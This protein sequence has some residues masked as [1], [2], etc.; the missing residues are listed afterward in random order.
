MIKYTSIRVMLAL[1]AHNS[2]EIEQIDVKKALLHGELND[3]IY[4]RQ[5]E[6]YEEGR[7]RELDCKLKKSLYGLKQSPWQWNKGFNSIVINLGFMKSYSD[8]CLYYKG[9]N[10]EEMV[11]ILIYVDD[12]LLVSS[13][14]EKIEK[15]KA[16]ISFE[17]EIKDLSHAQ[18]ILGICFIREREKNKLKIS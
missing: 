14:K 4:M 1:E 10:V 8:A 5:P 3:T 15:L 13:S 9:H 7:Q 2:C 6:G 11:I 16:Q 18:K 17:F 12:M